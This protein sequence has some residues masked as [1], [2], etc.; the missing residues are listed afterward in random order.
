L[1]ATHAGLDESRAVLRAMADD[2][3]ESITLRLV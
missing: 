2:L 3:A 1:K